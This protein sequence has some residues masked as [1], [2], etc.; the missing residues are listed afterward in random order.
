MQKAQASVH[1]PRFK[2]L[3]PSSP[4]SSNSKRRTPHRDTTPELL[5]R[6]LLWARGFRYRISVKGLVGRPDLV[7]SS[8]RL[9]VFCDGDFWHGRHWMTQRKKLL[10][11]SNA[12]YWIAK[13]ESNRRRDRRTTRL[14]RQQNW[15]VLRFWEGEIL[16]DPDHICSVIIDALRGELAPETPTRP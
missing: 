8:A 3:L 11:G 7:F 16:R 4:A 10:A 14:L 13:I 5:L 15:R 9:V 1:V 6:R 12:E 2:G